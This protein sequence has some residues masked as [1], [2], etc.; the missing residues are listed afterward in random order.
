MTTA[1]PRTAGDGVRFLPGEI[2]AGRYRMVGMLGRGGMGEVYRADDMKLGQ[3]VAL[4]FLTQQFGDDPARL[5]P[6]LDEVRLS[7]RVT[8]PNVCRVYDV[9]DVD[10]RHFLSMEYVDGEDLASLLRRIGRLPEDKAVQL[11]RQMCAGLA[12]AHDE[13][14]LHR[15][16]KP[17]NIMID[18]RGRA[19]ITDFGLAGASVGIAGRD[20]RVGTPEYMAPE[21]LDGA[22]LTV[23]TDLYAL[24][25]V[26]YE[27]FTGKP[28]FE[29]RSDYQLLATRGSLPSNPSSHVSGLDPVVERAILRCLEPDPARRPQS[30]AQL[31]ASLPG[32]D[33]LAMALAAGET[34]SP[35]LVARAGGEGTLRPRV[36]VSLVATALVALAAVWYAESHVMG[37]QNMVPLPKAPEEL[38]I[39]ARAAL[40][41]AGYTVRLPNSASGFRYDSGYFVHQEQSDQSLQ[42]WK[43]LATANPA[44]ISFWYREAPNALSPIGNRGYVDN[45]NPPL[46]DPGMTTVELDP[47]GHL[48]GLV[49]VPATLAETPGPWREPDWSPLFAAAGLVENEWQTVDP[50][51]PPASSADITRAWTRGTMRVEASAF[52]GRTTSFRRIPEWVR[53]TTVTPA[54][55]PFEA[56][57]LVGGGLLVLMI[58]GGGVLAR[59]NLRQGRGDRRG[60]FRL[61]AAIAVLGVAVDVLRLNTAVASTLQVF[62]SSVEITFAIS[63]VA[64]MFYIAVEPYVR[65]FWP[66]T[67]IAWNRVLDGQLRD[68]MVGRHI[69]LG[70]LAGM[71]GTL[72]DLAS[73]LFVPVSADDMLNLQTANPMPWASAHAYLAGLLTIPESSIFFSIFFLVFVFFSRLILRRPW[74]GYIVAGIVWILP[75]IGS[76]GWHVAVVS[77]ALGTIIELLVLIRL[78]LFA[79]VVTSVFSSWF[80]VSLTTD[81]HA[82]F[83]SQSVVTMLLFGALILYG[84][85]IS[86]GEQKLFK[87]SLLS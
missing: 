7:L 34:P 60:A 73:H 77:A 61:A 23:R 67:L 81:V 49:A 57:V 39:D 40:A 82:W 21:Q 5:E 75:V 46:T 70:A 29:I 86:L 83:F 55:S 47:S 85:W 15:D 84:G 69:L 20:A 50:I 53:P 25:L 22:E 87:E 30:A 4:K 19:K 80:Y 56:I 16:L 78:G 28:A 27:L 72:L 76:P 17:A 18:G 6:F 74:I 10:G 41:A 35:D 24:G 79:A 45:V 44:P 12:A 54:D 3:P 8:H 68:P 1:L 38:R 58:I 37:A 48:T 52:R 59:R 14:I 33:P 71:L 26:L 62:M 2:V 65:R 9:G 13:G 43:G 36:A 32:G 66:N 64:W 31:A 63:L 51:W 11:A 42:R